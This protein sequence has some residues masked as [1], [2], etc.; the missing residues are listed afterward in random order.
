MRIKSVYC[1][2]LIGYLSIL[3]LWSSD[4]Y[5]ANWQALGEIPESPKFGKTDYFVDLES[6]SID[7]NIRSVWL[8]SVFSK[9]QSYSQGKTYTDFLSFT[10]YNCPNK[11]YGVT[12]I[13]VY[14]PDGQLVGS[15]KQ[16]LKYVPIPEASL[17]EKIYGF[18]CN[19][20]K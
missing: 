11:T 19:Y 20:R 2:A 3:I 5:S 13:D 14:S 4:A 12:R 17:D 10:Y 16:D 15:E 7:G 6:I 18:V 9:P 8:K 1:R